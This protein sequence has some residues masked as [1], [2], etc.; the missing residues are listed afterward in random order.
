MPQHFHLH[1]SFPKR[2][3]DVSWQ[4]LI[5]KLTKPTIFHLPGKDQTKSLI[6][7]CLIH[8]N[9]TSGYKAVTKELNKLKTYPL[10]VYFLI[11]NIKAAQ[12]KPYFTHRDWEA[13][14]GFNRIWNKTDK[15]PLAK[16]ILTF[17][18]K[19]NPLACLDLHNNNGKNPAY[20]ICEG[21]RKEVLNLAGFLAEIILFSEI[22][23]GTFTEAMVKICPAVTLEC[24]QVNTK[25]AD[26]FAEQTL[27]RF[28]SLISLPKKEREIFPYRELCEINIK[29]K[30][31]FC[32]GHTPKP[33]FDLVLRDDIEDFNFNILK[34]GDYLGFAEKI[35]VLECL[36][37]KKR[38][39]TKDFFYLKD[40]QILAKQDLTL[41]MA[42]RKVNIAKLSNLCYIIEKVQ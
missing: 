32:F 1:Q 24:G 13:K 31:K 2:F 9:E 20:A 7:S 15:Y 42:V 27:E 11:A 18:K 38:P 19:A 4:K 3:Q 10:D 28:L 36:D 21:E 29:K 12:R 23:L 22:R 25:V 5:Q 14:P 39:V 40:G 41:A 33:G 34:K 8:G 30:I 6:I 37:K 17:L 35:D 26:D 16:E